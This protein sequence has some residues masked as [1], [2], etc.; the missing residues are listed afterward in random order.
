MKQQLEMTRDALQESLKQMDPAARRDMTRGL[1][2][3][4][5]MTLTLSLLSIYSTGNFWLTNLLIVGG[6]V[7]TIAIYKRYQSRRRKLAPV[8]MLSSASKCVWKMDREA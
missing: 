2:W 7:I 8:P 1:A 4:W 3:T 6:V 5:S